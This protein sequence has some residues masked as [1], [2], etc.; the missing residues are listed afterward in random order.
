MTVSDLAPPRSTRTAIGAGLLTSAMIGGSVP[1][2]GML[3]DYP[4]LTGQSMRYGLGAVL[5]LGWALARGSRLTRP[6]LADVPA[7]LAIVAV[8][9]LGFNACMIAAQRHADPGLV[10][11]VL[12]GS[13]LVLAVAVPLLART[14]PAVRTLFGA[15]V[16]VAGVVILSGGGTWSGPGLLLAVLTMLC[17]AGFTLFAVAVVRRRGGL[18]VSLWCHVIAA[19]S[20]AALA[21]FVDDSAAWRA[22]SGREATALLVVAV[23]TV[24]AFCIWY[25]AVGVL[26]ADR[27]GVLIGV[28]PVAG[29]V[30]SVALGAEPLTAAAVAG[31][32]VVG[33]GCVVGLRRGHA[34]S[35]SNS[36]SQ[37]SVSLM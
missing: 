30:V 33:L 3:V 35:G 2:S 23:L 37:S 9:M 10:A 24:V 31:V 29:L 22:P 16:V 5:L 19:V 1:V 12:G 8:G 20:G 34:D 7:L 26:G 25:H 18:S 27:A 17:E 6:R 14:R 15:G 36:S 4:L 28:M 32:C 13:P 21:S 11:A